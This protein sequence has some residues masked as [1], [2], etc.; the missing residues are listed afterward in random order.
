MG[1]S[2]TGGRLHAWAMRIRASKL[3]VAVVAS[4]AALL[5][6]AI[7]CGTVNRNVVVLPSTAS[8]GARSRIMSEFPAGTTV[9]QTRALA[10]TIVTE[11]GIAHLRG[12]T[13]RE[14]ALE[15]VAISDPHFRHELHAAARELFW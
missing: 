1:N 15:L 6:I 7:S 12:K 11:H 9:T 10:D 14:R 8:D 13:V 2:T 3:R 4:L 5:V